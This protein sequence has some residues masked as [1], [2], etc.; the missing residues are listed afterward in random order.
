MI[1]IFMVVII[2]NQNAYN[3]INDYRREERQAGRR[4]KSRM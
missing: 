4:A 3:M 1:L 2:K